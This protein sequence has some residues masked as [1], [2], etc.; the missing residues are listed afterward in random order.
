MAETR[1]GEEVALAEEAGDELVGR[2]PVERLGRAELV[3]SGP[4]HHGDAV[5]HGQRLLLV[6]GDEDEGDADLVLD[7]LEL[8]L[9]PLA[10]PPVER[11]ERLV[12]QQ[13]LRPRHQRAGERHPLLL[14][15]GQLA[16]APVAQA[17]EADQ[18]EHGADPRAGLGGG[19][20]R[21]LQAVGDVAGDGQVREERVALEHRVDRPAMGRR[22]ADAPAVDQD[23]AGVERL[24]A[25]DGAQERGL[26]AARRTEERQ[27]LARRHR[28][29]QVVEGDHV[30]ALGRGEALGRVA[31]SRGSWRTPPWRAR[32]AA[33]GPRRSLRGLDPGPFPS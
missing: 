12:E 19:H 16:D 18:L 11:G 17:A 24:E 4:R 2:M 5:G 26:A 30:A 32:T 28:Q 6:V 10:E 27:E 20:L 25:A 9:H 29:R 8:L 14:A 22:V 1:A 13:D 15:A 7:G 33:P 21:D 3:R 31:D 23:L